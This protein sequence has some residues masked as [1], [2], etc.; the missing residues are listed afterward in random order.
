MNTRGFADKSIINLFL[1]FSKQ[2]CKP[3]F[4]R[5]YLSIYPPPQN[6]SK[7]CCFFLF[8]SITK[9]AHACRHA[10]THSHN[11]HRFLA[12]TFQ[13]YISFVVNTHLRGGHVFVDSPSLT[14]CGSWDLTHSNVRRCEYLSMGLKQ[15][16][17]SQAILRRLNKL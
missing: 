11:F 15:E 16:C 10:R 6:L 8:H 9:S 17:S 12:T 14:F 5:N 1:N 3:G 4:A 2:S 7:L 13:F